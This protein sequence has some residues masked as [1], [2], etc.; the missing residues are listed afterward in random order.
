MSE[1]PK[2]QKKAAAQRR[3]AEALRDNLQRRKA[4]TRAR[5]E[6]VKGDAKGDAR[7]KPHDSAGISVEK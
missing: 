2:Q 5:K 3:L 1:H 6:E 7:A 4:Q